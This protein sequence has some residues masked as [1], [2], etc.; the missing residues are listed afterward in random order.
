MS[1]PIYFFIPQAFWRDD[2]PETSDENWAGF[3]LGMYTWTIQTYLRLREHGIRCQLTSQLPEEG[4]VF[5]HANAPRRAE[6]RP[7]ARRLLICLKA[8]SILC[9]Q[10][11]I[12][13]VQNPSEVG[14]GRYFMPHWPQPGLRPRQP[15]RQDR[16]ETI[17]FL[18]H[19]NSLAP[20]LQTAA[21]QSGLEQRG[22]RWQ[23]VVNRNAWDDAGAIDTRWNDYGAIDAIVAVRRFHLGRPGYGRKPGTKLYNAWL[24]GVPAILGRELAYRRAGTAG[25]DYLEANSMAELWACL[26]RLQHDQALRKAL[27]KDGQAQAQHYT[28]AAITHRWQQFLETVAIPAYDRWCSQSS[29]Q[30]RLAQ[31]QAQLLHYGDRTQR[32]LPHFR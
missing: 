22:L 9:P 19:H 12:H 8:E 30:Q 28:A 7:S 29:W 18:G 26:D 15:E 25:V 24:A 1:L 4:I 23:A 31:W 32:K 10:A 13:V 11:Q 20:E 14:L 21:W 5:F 2:I 27:V 6:I 16:F 17:A 3:G